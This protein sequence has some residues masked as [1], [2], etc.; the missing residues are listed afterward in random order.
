MRR[1]L[2]KGE[3]FPPVGEKQTYLLPPADELAHLTN[4]TAA[5]ALQVLDQAHRR[6]YAYASLAMV[7][8]TIGLL[9]CVGTFA[10]LVVA[11]HPQA[12]GIVLGAGVL[13]IVGQIVNS[14]L[15]KN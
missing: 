2:Q 5:A 11:N 12:A 7:C 13:T 1:G 8:G 6:E 9:A 4:E 3:G 14:R 15:S 10:Y